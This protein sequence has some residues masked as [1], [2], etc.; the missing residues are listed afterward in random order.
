VGPVSA[1]AIVSAIAIVGGVGLFFAAMIALTQRKF[2]VW[3]DPRI[4][5]VAGFLPGA[6]CGACGQAGCRAFAEALVGGAVKPALCTVSSVDTLEDIAAYLGVAVGEANRR[7]AR[8]SCAGGCDVAPALV[9]YR[10]LRTCKAA[11]AVNGGGKACAWGCLGLAD[12]ALACTFGAIRMNAVGL[13]VV[14]PDKCTAC[15]DCVTAC[16]KGLFTLMPAD[17]HLIVQCKSAVE[18]DRAER[19]CKV[20]CTACG[21]CAVDGAPGL[22]EI[23]DGLAVIDYSKNELARPGAAARCPTGA[24]V[25][26]EGPQFAESPKLAEALA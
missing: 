6:N 14:I 3:E 23:T 18:G 22:I 16:P 11:A 2:Y 4:D 9:D 1:G 20:A 19:V 15:G 17:H 25:W 8:L 21:K 13:P 7:V 5:E 10:G 12:C 24:I 26:V